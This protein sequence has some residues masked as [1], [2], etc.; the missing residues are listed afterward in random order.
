MSAYLVTTPKNP[1]YE[2]KVFGIQFN[3]GRAVVSKETINRSLGY[4]VEEIVHAMQKDFGYEV[5]PI[6]TDPTPAEAEK[7][8]RNASKRRKSAE[9]SEPA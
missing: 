4:T 9:V 1:A 5:T 3:S 2:G 8:N 6:G 7:P